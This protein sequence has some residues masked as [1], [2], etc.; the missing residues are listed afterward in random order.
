MVWTVSEAIQHEIESKTNLKN[1]CA[2]PNPINCSEINKKAAEKCDLVFDSEKTNIVMIGRLSKEKGF[3]R[4]IEFMCN[5]VFKKYPNTH[6]YILG[7][8]NIDGYKNFINKFEHNEKISLLGAKENPF[9]YLKQSQLLIC[10]SIDESFGLVLLEAMF[11]KIP[12]ITTDTVGGKYVTQ[13]NTLGCCVNNSAPALQAAVEA[14]LADANTYK[15]SLDAAKNWAEQHDLKFFEKRIL[16]L[17]EKC[18]K[19]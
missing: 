1:V 17:L 7:G 5:N 14:F 8:G 9:P 19:K 12:V 13:H 16:E 18:D 11:L 3:A 6:L 15:Y 4:V 10:P 2:L